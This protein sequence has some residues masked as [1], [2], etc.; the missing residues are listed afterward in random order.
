MLRA[1]APQLLVAILLWGTLGGVAYSRGAP[2]WV[3]YVAVA[4]GWL[5]VLPAYLRWEN[6]H[7]E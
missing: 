1:L 2:P 4:L 3:A 6:R 5:T 7:H